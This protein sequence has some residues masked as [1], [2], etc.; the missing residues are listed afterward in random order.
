[1]NKTILLLMFLVFVPFVSAGDLNVKL[2]SVDPQEVT[3]GNLFSVSFEAVNTGS[4]AVRDPVFRLVLPSSFSFESKSKIDFDEVG[5]KERVILSW[6]LRVN[7]F[8]NPGLEKLELEVEEGND[9]FSL[10]FPVKVNT[11]EPTL[12]IDGFFTTPDEVAPGSQL[13]LSLRLDNVASFDLRNIDVSIDLSKVPFSPIKGVDKDNFNQLSRNS[14]VTKQI[15]LIVDPEAQAGIYKIP[16]KV[17]Y[18]DEFGAKYFK[19]SLI[20]IKIGSVPKIEIS[21]ESSK[22]VVGQKS[23]ATIKLVN[24]GLTKIK[25]LTINLE[26]VNAELVSSASVYLGDL[27]VDDFQTFDVE[28]FTGSQGPVLVLK[29]DFKDANNKDFSETVNVPLKIYS[30]DDAKRLGIVQESNAF[31]YVIIII[32]VLIIYFVYRKLKRK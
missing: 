14:R 11:L 16:L 3:S 25:L 22:L 1:M 28:L 5:S 15:N 13:A 30:R 21:Q 18:L 12:V 19:E 7:K 20:S 26:A 31:I 4:N 32:V 10:F 17:S 8:A 27:D 23:E 29:L 24:N 6:L 2:L 9:K